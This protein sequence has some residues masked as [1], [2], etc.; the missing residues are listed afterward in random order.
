M[1]NKEYK[2]GKI[3][4]NQNLNLIVVCKSQK[5]AVELFN[6]QA[7]YMRDYGYTMEPR[8]QIAIDNPETIYAIADSGV[9]YRERPDLLQK[10]MLYSELKKIIDELRDAGKK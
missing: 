4:G 3:Y 2:I 5:R 1:K 8:T 6:T 10:I 7:S 9:I